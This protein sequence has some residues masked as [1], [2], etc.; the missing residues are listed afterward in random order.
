M[1]SLFALFTLAFVALA[2]PAYGNEEYGSLPAPHQDNSP[3]VAVIAIAVFL[4]VGWAFFV[5]FR[6]YA[7]NNSNNR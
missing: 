5:L 2:A 4:G 7:R 3:W 6:S 1:R